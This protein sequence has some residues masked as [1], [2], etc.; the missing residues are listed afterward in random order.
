RKP[1]PELKNRFDEASE[2]TMKVLNPAGSITR[3]L[4]ST[5]YETL[6]SDR[7]VRIEVEGEED[8]AALPCIS[9]ADNGSQ[10]A[11]GLPDQGLVLVEVNDE[12]KNRVRR[13]LE[14]MRESNAS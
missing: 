8:L 11:Y 9:L 2:V 5:I 6:P 10:V 13:I 14:R 3:G 4:W 12:S 1:S 7:K